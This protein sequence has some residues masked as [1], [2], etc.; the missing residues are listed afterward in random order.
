MADKKLFLLDAFALIYRAYYGL[1]GNALT[2]SKGMNVTAINLFTRTMFDLQKKEGC[3]HFG[4]VFDSPEQTD[5]AVEYEF[6]KAN[7]E[8]MPEDIAISIPYI[9]EIVRASNIPLIELAGY[10]ADDLIGTLA[11]MAEKKGFQTYMVTPD[12]D[13]A[14]LVS[15]NIFMYKPQYKGKGYDII[16]IPEV[17]EKWMVERPEQVIDILGMWGDA[18]DNIPGIPGVGEKTAKKF[19]QAYGSLEG[20]LENTDDLKGKMKE[21]VIEFAEQARVS[22]HLATII[23][24][25]PI[26]FKE[27]DFLLEAPNKEKLAPIF[28]EL[29]FRTL[30]KQLLGDSYNVVES[31]SSGGRDLFSQG[32]NAKAGGQ[33][34]QAAAKSGSDINS[35]KHKYELVNDAAGRKKLLATLLKQK[36]VCFDTETTGVDPTNCELVGLAFSFKKGTGYYVPCPEDQKVTQEILNDFKP[37]WESQDILKIAHNLKF[38]MMVL[39]AYQTEISTPYYD[40]MIAHY[41]VKPEMRHNMDLLAETYLAY[42]P[43][44]IESLI[45][46]K[47]PK[48]GSMRDVE[49]EKAKEYAVEDAD[50]TF[51]LKKEFAPWVKKEKLETLFNEVEIPLIPVLADMEMKGVAIDTKFLADYSK[52]LERDALD[53]QSKIFR[54]AN[55]EF[56]LNSPKQMG[57]VLFDNLKIPYTGKKTKTGQYSTSEDVL[58]KLAGEHEIASDILSFREVAKLRSTYVDALP[59]LINPKTGRIHSSF[60]QAVVPTGRL[61]SDKPNL[62]NIPIRTERGRKIRNAFISGDKDFKIFSADYSQVELRIIAALGNET[63]MISAFKNG[64]DIHSAT[65]A[66]VFGVDLKDVDRDMRRKAKAV[67]FGLAYGQSA[68]GLAQSLSI[69]R[70]EAKEIIEN[71]FEKYPGILSYMEDSKEFARKNGFVRTILGRKRNLPDINSNNNTVRSFAER[72]AVNTPIQ[73]SAADIIKKAMI[74]IHGAMDKGKFKSR[75]ILQVHDELVFEVHKSEEKSLKELVHDKMSNAVTLSVPLTVES[76]IGKNWLEAH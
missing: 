5:R 71:Y 65:A 69:S 53:F 52:I 14:Q 57:A 44:S 37:F 23:L 64:E 45:G 6:Y 18:V 49:I 13:Y 73:G 56:N 46:K 19:I 21:K 61:S 31:S 48:Q 28:A 63:N 74:D 40:S 72:N 8:A 34:E 75:M 47:G 25:C 20:L 60:R 76:G 27:K 58:S 43:Q 7:R 26:K 15:E 62:Q 1:G 42:T 9:K 33:D 3:T 36:E 11:K 50:I 22:K 39:K 17:Q 35:S 59:K 30:G 66:K 4:V 24:D 32:D 2:N 51:Q 68:F 10:E 55:V 38:D 70:T 41:L 67:N 29:E 12:K 54:K 16:G